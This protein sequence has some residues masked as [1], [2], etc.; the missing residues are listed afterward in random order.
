[1][2]SRSYRH[3]AFAYY[4]AGDMERRCQSL[5][6][7][8]HFER[9][10]DIPWYAIPVLREA[11][12]RSGRWWSVRAALT[13]ATLDPLVQKHLV[14]TLLIGQL[15]VPKAPEV[16]R[17]VRLAAEAYLANAEWMANPRQDPPF[18]TYWPSDR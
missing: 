13:N 12:T 18:R 7:A 2:G 1:M 16:Q 3:V 9:E 4:V 10:R 6:W 17:V 11:R 14:E 15:P 8:A 5:A